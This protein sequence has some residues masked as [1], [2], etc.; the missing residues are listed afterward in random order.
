MEVS[1]P[2]DHTFD[3]SNS[4]V[5]ILQPEEDYTHHD[6]NAFLDTTLI[7]GETPEFETVEDN[8]ISLEMTPCVK[9][10]LTISLFHFARWFEVEGEKTNLYK[11]PEMYETGDMENNEDDDGVVLPPK[12]INPF[13]T[14]IRPNPLWLKGLRNIPPFILYRCDKIDDADAPRMEVNHKPCVRQPRWWIKGKVLRQRRTPRMINSTS[15]RTLSIAE[16]MYSMI[17]LHVPHRDECFDLVNRSDPQN[18]TNEEMAGIFQTYKTQI[19]AD[20]A[21]VHSRY[22]EDLQRCINDLELPDYFRHAADLSGVVPPDHSHD[23][24][25]QEEETADNFNPDDVSY[26][27]DLVNVPTE[28]QSNT[29][30][31]SSSCAIELDD[32]QQRAVNIFRGYCFQLQAWFKDKNLSKPEPPHIFL[33][34]PAGTGKTATVKKIVDTIIDYAIDASKFYPIKNNGVYITASTGVAARM[35]MGGQTTHTAL[36]MKPDKRKNITNLDSMMDKLHSEKLRQL[37]DAWQGVILLIID[38]CSMTSSFMLYLIH[39]RL[40]V[41]F[42]TQGQPGVYLEALQCYLLVTF[43]N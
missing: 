42:G 20:S 1:I 7:H 8:I 27:E 14:I 35:F 10:W 23:H 11:Q 39:L 19:V 4:Q 26:E 29:G 40:S 38:E 25:N 36:G 30:A 16:G 2:E 17:Q 18:M 6:Q 5:N 33:T 37:Q 32:D 28:E 22:S 15:H 24:R 41:I 43:I 31:P 21:T 13:D 3:F 9:V 34:G 12:C